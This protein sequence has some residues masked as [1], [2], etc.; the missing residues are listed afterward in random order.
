MKPG[1]PQGIEVLVRKAAVDESFRARLLA[2]RA[3]AATDIGLE[4]TAAEAAML[5]VVPESQLDAIVARVDVPVE[6]RRAFLGQAATAM[7]AAL[8]AMAADIPQAN[9]GKFGG[10]GGGGVRVSGPRYNRTLPIAPQVIMVIAKELDIDKD[11][12]SPQTD[13]AQDLHATWQQIAA[14]RMAIGKH[15]GLI[16]NYDRFR[17]LRTVGEVVAYI[18]RAVKQTEPKSE[19]P[20][21]P[22]GDGS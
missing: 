22:A 12:I 15:F 4:L 19:M 21:P 3:A 10:I 17:K 18:E 11:Q 20:K 13:L 6:H 7:L 14:I 1:L 5:A 9:A 16:L 8:A 2:A